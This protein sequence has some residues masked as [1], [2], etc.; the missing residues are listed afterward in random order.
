M[1]APEELAAFRLQLERILASPEFRGSQQLRDFL[2]Y[3]SEQA[4]AGRASIDQVEIAER[5]L[6]RPASFNPVEDASVRKLATQLRRKLEQHYENGGTADPVLVTLPPRTYVPLF[7]YRAP[8]EIPPVPEPARFRISRRGWML[9]AAI[10]IVALVAWVAGR[11]APEPGVF[12]FQT[13]GGNFAG[14]ATG[15][16]PEALR[17]GPV[18]RE[19]DEAVVRMTFTPQSIHQQA[20]LL[21]Y[22]DTDNYAAFSRHFRS[23]PTLEFSL[24]TGGRY[25]LT[26]AA[27]EYDP[28][29]G[30]GQPIWL[31]IRRL[32]SRF[33]AFTS[34]DGI[35]WKQFGHELAMPQPL[36]SARVGLFACSGR[37][38][39][40][41]AAA[42]FDRLGTGLS[43]HHWEDNFLEQWQA[44]GW[45]QEQVCGGT[46]SSAIR[47]G[48]LEIT[49][50][51]RAPGPCFWQLTR[52]APAGDWRITTL[53][54]YLP[55]PGAHI[56][57]RVGAREWYNLERTDAE[58]GSIRGDTSTGGVNRPDFPGRPPVFLRIEAA[59]GKLS[60]FY[61][62]DSAQYLTVPF[63]MAAASLGPDP[64]AGIRSSLDPW[65]KDTRP[66][67]ARFYFV[68]QEIL[69]LKNYR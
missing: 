31:A 61:S 44:A 11:P 59:G 32:G 18:L 37:D 6:H 48:A 49:L 29:G 42:V 3:S 4:F 51:R 47:N 50:D 62:R 46:A 25:Q 33:R 41:P 8:D 65:N 54:D 55:V 38:M 69:T 14:S 36:S 56:A 22:Q 13:L 28:A 16:P 39:G 57:L 53:A 23:R 52:P 5:V 12:Q 21:I 9:A 58:G 1:Y 19:Y 35:E 34:V 68:R 63:Q 66:Q 15:L 27:V 20:G 17:V 67:P 26:D 43:F 30:N 45:R 24:E 40:P 60:G 10:P 7:R 2:A 64:R